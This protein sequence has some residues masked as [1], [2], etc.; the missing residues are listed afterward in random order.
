MTQELETFTVTKQNK[1][2][3]KKWTQIE[4]INA[5]DVV[6]RSN[7]LLAPPSE[8]V[9]M[10]LE[11]AIT[12]AVMKWRWNADTNLYYTSDFRKSTNMIDYGSWHDLTTQQW[13][14]V[15]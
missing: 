11:V 3:M 8:I 6:L 14:L 1:K 13:G 2:Q 10:S 7:G 9:I 5:G 12:Y 4:E 15:K